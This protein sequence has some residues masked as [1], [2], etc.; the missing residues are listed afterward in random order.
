MDLKSQLPADTVSAMKHIK[1]EL[2]MKLSAIKGV[3]IEDKEVSLS[4]HYRQVSFS[5]V[6]LVKKIIDKLVVL[7]VN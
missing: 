6:P 4:V 3:F 7:F 2:I 5:Q 1:I